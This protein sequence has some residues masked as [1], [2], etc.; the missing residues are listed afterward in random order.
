MPGAVAGRDDQAAYFLLC[1]VQDAKLQA[2]HSYCAL[3]DAYMYVWPLPSLSQ[4]VRLYEAECDS[5]S[6]HPQHGRSPDQPS[7]QEQQETNDEPG[8]S[9]WLGRLLRRRHRL[10]AQQPFYGI[11]RTQAEGNG[12]QGSSSSW[13]LGDELADRPYRC[14]KQVAGDGTTSPKQDGSPK[15]QHTLCLPISRMLTSQLPPDEHRL[16][17]NSTCRSS[18][19]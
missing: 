16:S 19:S 12:Q 13:A 11:G 8:G 14:A 4:Q 9:S 17:E 3:F 10:S 2:R 18:A 6:Q 15:H 7:L 5:P 1:T